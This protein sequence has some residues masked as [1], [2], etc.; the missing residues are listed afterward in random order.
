MAHNSQGVEFLLA[1]LEPFWQQHLTDI[2][3]AQQTSV[4]PAT[5]KMIFSMLADKDIDK[6]VMQLTQANL[7]ISDWYVG[8]IDYPRAATSSQLSKVL[9]SYI[10]ED[11]I[12][13]LANLPQATAAVIANSQPQDLIVVCGSFHTIG[14]TLASL[15]VD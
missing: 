15:A 3:S 10:V 11:Q 13:L 6:V 12:H 5:I 2:N 4:S 7:P 1:Q 14:E 8:E 9:T